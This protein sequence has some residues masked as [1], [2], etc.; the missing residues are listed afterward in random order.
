M[1][2]LDTSMT[3]QDFIVTPW[4]ASGNIDYDR[5]IR[6]FGVSKL[7]DSLLERLEAIAKKKGMPLHPWL[8]RKIFFAH[9]DLNLVLDDY[10]KGKEFFLY[11]GRGPSGKMHIGHLTPFLFTKYLQDLFDVELYIQFTDDEKFLFKEDLNLEQIAKFTRDDMIDVAAVGFDPK[12]THFI[13]D[14]MHA[15]LLYPQAIRVAKRITFST[16]KS[17]FGFSNENNIGQIFFTAM[18]AVP[19]FL[20]SVLKGKNLRCLIP[21]AID[22]DPHFRVSR[23]VIPKLGYYKPSS[24]QCRFLPSLAGMESSGKMSA[25]DEAMAINLTD[26]R[27]T[28][29]KKIHKYAFSGGRE[30]MEAHR[31]FGGNPD[32]DIAYQWLCFFEEDDAKLARYY[33]D[34]KSGKLLSSELKETVSEKL[35]DL[36]EAHQKRR[37]K[38]EKDVD[39]FLLKI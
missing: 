20:P 32:V 37:A 17:S 27:E 8:R 4:N 33:N 11:T 24:I 28:V 38:A 36:L 25:S 21:H 29:R 3:S 12:K 9:R 31:K 26:S 10:E 6:E 1:T 16:V 35:S 23:D 2:E 18:Q 22:Q 14:N 34:Y 19:A 7:D 39:K 15:G 30:T 5:V 13:V